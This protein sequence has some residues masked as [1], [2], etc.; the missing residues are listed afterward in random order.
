MTT[1]NQV[2][3]QVANSPAGRHA[4]E[5]A[6]EAVEAARDLGD[7]VTDFASDAARKAEDFASQSRGRRASNSPA[8]N[9]AVDTYEEAHELSAQN[10]PHISLVHCARDRL[11]G[12]RDPGHAPLVLTF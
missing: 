4:A 2:F 10:P 9:A 1:A 3:R 6:K 8:R 12:W 7:Q 11:P 5:S